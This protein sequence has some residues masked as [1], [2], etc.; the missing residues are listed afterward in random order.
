MTTL[1][2]KTEKLSDK[3]PMTATEIK[4]REVLVVHGNE[5]QHWRKFFDLKEAYLQQGYRQALEDLRAKWPSK[6][7]MFASV[8]HDYCADAYEAG[9]DRAYRWL[10]ERLFKETE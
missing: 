2:E 3:V 9:Q 10:H 4:F 6:E 8:E 7:E 5:K 1:D